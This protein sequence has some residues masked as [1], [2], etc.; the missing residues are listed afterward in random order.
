MAFTETRVKQQKAWSSQNSHI[1]YEA[2]FSALSAENS[3]DIQLFQLTLS[4]FKAS[5]LHDKTES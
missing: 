5:S 1:S 4:D 2:Y 3:C